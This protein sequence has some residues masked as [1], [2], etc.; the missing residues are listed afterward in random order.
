MDWKLDAMRLRGFVINAGGSSY[1]VASAGPI[2]NDWWPLLEQEGGNPTR[3]LLSAAVTKSPQTFTS[4]DL[5]ARVSI[6]SPGAGIE[7]TTAAMGIEEAPGLTDLCLM[8]A[9]AY[10]LAVIKAVLLMLAEYRTLVDP[11]PDVYVEVGAAQL[12]LATVLDVTA[13]AAGAIAWT[14]SGG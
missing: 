14:H 12:P 8:A 11:V 10:S 7:V 3:P 6:V 13:E 9:H 5:S 1:L 2:L 4:A